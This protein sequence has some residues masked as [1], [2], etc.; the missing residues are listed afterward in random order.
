MIFLGDI[1]GN[2][3]WLRYVIENNQSAYRNQTI[4]QV[5]DFGVGFTTEYND[6]KT[7]E[8]L[9]KFLSKF[10]IIMYVLKGNHDNPLYFK[11]NHIF[12]NLKLMPDYSVIEVEGSKILL[13]GGALSIDRSDR[14]KY[15]QIAASQGISRE[16][17]WFDEAFALDEKKIR[18]K[19]LGENSSNIFLLE[20]FDYNNNIVRIIDMPRLFSSIFLK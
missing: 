10:N 20:E 15:M 11:G 6:N 17:Y 12:N 4:I 9:D 1:H 8:D 14:L 7:L 16:S 2:C 19:A 13:V 18:S 5:G 3:A